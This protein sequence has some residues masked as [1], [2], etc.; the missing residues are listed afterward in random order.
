M[1]GRYRSP[2]GRPLGF[3]CDLEGYR[4]GVP[5]LRGEPLELVALQKVKV[6]RKRY[7]NYI[8]YSRK[9]NTIVH[10]E[11]KNPL[12]ISAFS[13]NA[14]DNQNAVET[15][16]SPDEGQKEWLDRNYYHLIGRED[17]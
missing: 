6:G 15:F 16:L 3:I 5:S 11:R 2:S 4:R 14:V 9:L 8:W 10:A 13:A 12:G 7:T 17:I 1:V